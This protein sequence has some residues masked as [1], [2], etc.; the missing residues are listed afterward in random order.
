[1]RARIVKLMAAL[2]ALA[3]LAIGGS[4]LA[5][6]GSKATPQ[7]AKQPAAQ[8]TFNQS[9]ASEQP[10]TES[11]TEQPEAATAES[12]SEQAANDG[13]GGHA[14]EPGNANADHQFEGV[15]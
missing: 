11:T 13:P 9:P 4:T 10:G 2:S 3:V 5:S 1:M 7:P 15:E 8:S 14:D 12:G 6:A